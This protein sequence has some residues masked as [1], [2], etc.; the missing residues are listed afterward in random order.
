MAIV[1]VGGSGRGVGKTSLVCGLIAAFPEHRWIAVKIT[2]HLHGQRELLWEEA[3]PGHGT[4]T[5]RYLAAGAR[6]AFLVTAVD[7]ELRI[8]E[9]R[10]AFGPGANVIFESNRIV[11][12][13]RPDLCIGA[14]GGTS[15][16][17]KASFEPFVGRA[18]AFVVGAG[19]DFGSLKL[20]SSAKIFRLARFDCISRE[21]IDWVLARLNLAE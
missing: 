5:A 16:E 12:V 20:P 4:D 18:D 7:E 8:D 11:E 17:V 13:L 21:M 19:R 10:A 14:M 6:R 15:G 2:G 9:I 1:V 3:A